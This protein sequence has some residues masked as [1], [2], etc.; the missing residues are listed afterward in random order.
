MKRLVIHVKRRVQLP[1]VVNDGRHLD[2][3]GRVRGRQIETTLVRN[4][5]EN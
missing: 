4:H 1:Q 3:G 2:R 5:R